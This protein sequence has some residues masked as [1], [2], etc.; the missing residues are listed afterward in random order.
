MLIK[1]LIDGNAACLNLEGR[2]DFHSQQDFRSA[3]ETMLT[4]PEIG[5]LRLDFS[6]VDYLDS[7]ALGMLLLLRE[8]A[9]AAGKRVKLANLS[10]VVKQVVEIA[11]FG[12]LFTIQ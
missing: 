8:E 5:E 10:G 2:F 11:N 7:S 3:Y 9:D 12:K 1:E 6:R 4:K